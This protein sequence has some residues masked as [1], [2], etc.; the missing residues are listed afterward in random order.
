MG[1]LYN[2]EGVPRVEDD[3]MERD[4][5][6]SQEDHQETDGRQVRHYHHRLRAGYAIADELVDEPKAGLSAWRVD[7]PGSL[8]I[9]MGVD[10]LVPKLRKGRVAGGMD[11][12]A[13]PVGLD[14]AVPDVAV[15][16]TG[17]GGWRSHQDH[18]KED[19][20]AE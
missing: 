16:V 12:R 6:L 3:P 10:G 1:H 18:P 2:Y 17:E 11:P 13:Q 7:G 15:H 8:A 5:H 14:P 4:P 19:G 9:D 20:H